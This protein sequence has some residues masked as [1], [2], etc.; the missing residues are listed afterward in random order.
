MN[1]WFTILFLGEIRNIWFIWIW[2]QW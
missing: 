1:S 2:P